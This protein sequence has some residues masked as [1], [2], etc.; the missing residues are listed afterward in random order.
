[1]QSRGTKSTVGVRLPPL[2]GITLS[3]EKGHRE[4]ARGAAVLVG[5]QGRQSARRCR[6]GTG[7]LRGAGD[8]PNSR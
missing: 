5:N 3:D 4:N 8:F 6:A 7:D 2:D 1:V